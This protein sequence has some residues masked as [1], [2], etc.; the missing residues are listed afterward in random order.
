MPTIANAIERIEQ[1]RTGDGFNEGNHPRA[2][3]GQ[4]SSGGGGS[5]SSSSKPK[6]RK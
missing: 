2:S 5:G 6:E 1:A 3:N 4:F